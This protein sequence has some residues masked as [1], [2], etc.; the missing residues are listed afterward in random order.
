MTTYRYRATLPITDPDMP[1]ADLRDEAVREFWL[2]A[3]RDEVYPRREPVVTIAGDRVIVEAPALPYAD[4]PWYARQKVIAAAARAERPTDDDGLDPVHT[5]RVAM[6]HVHAERTQQADELLAEEPSMTLDQLAEAVGV[7]RDALRGSLK[8]TGRT[9]LIERIGRTRPT[10]DR[11]DQIDRLLASD[12][13]ATCAE[14]ARHLG[15][16]VQAVWNVTDRSGRDDLRTTLIANGKTRRKSAV[17]MS[18]AERAQ[19]IADMLGLEPTA[20]T[21]QVADRL[22]TSRDVIWKALRRADRDDLL[23]Q[24][25]RNAPGPGRPRTR[26]TA[27]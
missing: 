2:Q 14:V 11:V 15:I 6:A 8:R 13:G 16:T 3:H 4:L 21:Q 26:T 17:R 5:K 27:A 18:A 12:G 19:Q 24:L 23:E 10:A 1:R 9:D 20:T 25:V 22:N 7:S